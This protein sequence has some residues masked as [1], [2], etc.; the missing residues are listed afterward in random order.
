MSFYS[1]CLLPMALNLG[2]KL[3]AALHIMAS[4]IFWSSAGQWQW[5]AGHVDMTG[6][7]KGSSFLCKSTNLDTMTPWVKTGMNC[8]I[9][10]LIFFIVDPLEMLSIFCL[11][12]LCKDI[13]D[14]FY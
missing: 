2:T 11:S 3:C 4:E 9:R 5:G 10:L 6:Y 1:V 7:T 13:W 14:F 12:V 8:P